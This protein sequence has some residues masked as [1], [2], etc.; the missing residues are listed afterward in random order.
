MTRWLDRIAAAAVRAWT[1]VYTCGM[2][3][4]ARDNRR[5]EIESDLWESRHDPDRDAGLRAAG[6]IVL[7]LVLGVPD[8][9]FW[10]ASRV[11]GRRVAALRA[12]ATVMLF[13]VVWAYAQWLMS[14]PLPEPPLRPMQFVSD[15][16]PPPPPPPPPPSLR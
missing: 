5:M 2:S 11:T 15:S 12:A 16:P 4:G 8:D 1:R 3:A 9:L 10:R 6:R 7:R 14:T 13:L